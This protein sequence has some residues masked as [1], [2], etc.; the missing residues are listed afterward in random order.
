[1]YLTNVPIPHPARISGRRI[2]TT[3]VLSGDVIGTNAAQSKEIPSAT[4]LKTLVAVAVT[5]PSMN[6]RAR[7]VKLKDSNR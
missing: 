5:I 1:M 6:G 3:P 2:H 7:A 4:R